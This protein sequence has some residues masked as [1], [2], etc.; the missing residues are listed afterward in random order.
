MGQESKQESKKDQ[1][2]KSALKLFSKHGYHETA[3]SKI[4]DQAGV[5][6][7]TVYWY[8]DSKEKLFLEII[9]T[10]IESLN[11]KLEERVAKLNDNSIEKIKVFIELYLEFFK[12]GEDTAKIV[13]E[14]SVSFDEYFHKEMVKQRQLAID[15]L[16]EIIKEGKNNNKIKNEIDEQEVANLILGT[17]FGGYNPHVYQL[18]DVE[19]KVDFISNIILNGIKT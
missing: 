2:M 8:F 12:E 1:I 7:G 13:Q 10:G 17:L 18:T 6:K 3:V 5:A 11:Q 14:S 19:E 16:A 15:N 4:A 9:I